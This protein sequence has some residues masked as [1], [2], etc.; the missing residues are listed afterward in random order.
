LITTK[1]K[2]K[3]TYLWPKQQLMSFGPT[4]CLAGMFEGGGDGGEG[5]GMVMVG[6]HAVVVVVEQRGGS[7]GARRR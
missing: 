2:K 1:N 3:K 7:K 4:F 6:V 5:I